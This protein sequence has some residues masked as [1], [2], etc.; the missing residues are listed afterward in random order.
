MALQW[1]DY[2]AISVNTAQF[3]RSVLVVT[4]SMSGLMRSAIFTEGDTALLLGPFV[5]LSSVTGTHVK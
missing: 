1:L 5:G 3:P 2:S 4:L